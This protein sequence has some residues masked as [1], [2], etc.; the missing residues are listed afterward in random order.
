MMP[1]DP[2]LTDKSSQMRESSAITRKKMP[3]TG[4]A[5]KPH[6]CAQCQY[7]SKNASNLRRHMLSKHSDAHPHICAVCSRPFNRSDALLG[8]IRSVH[9]RLV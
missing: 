9:L 6:S 5:E 1:D 7:S 2:R 3:Q 4:S 8:H